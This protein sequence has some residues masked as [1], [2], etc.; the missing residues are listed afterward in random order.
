MAKFE[1]VLAQAPVWLLRFT[2][3]NWTAHL[4]GIACPDVSAAP[5]WGR[6]GLKT[7]EIGH[8]C[9]RERCKLV[10]L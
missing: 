1:C 3:A 5:A 4:L 6:D 10:I 2:R 8:C 7:L 9:L